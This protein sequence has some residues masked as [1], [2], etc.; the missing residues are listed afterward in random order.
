SDP[1]PE[2][3]QRMTVRHAVGEASLSG[4]DGT[5]IGAGGNDEVFALGEVGSAWFGMATDPFWA[6][7]AALAVFIDSRSRGEDAPGVFGPTPNNVFTD[8]NVVAIALQLPNAV[9]GGDEVALWA[10]ITL[11]GHAGTTRVSRTGNPMVR[12]L[13]FPDR[14][15]QAEDLNAGA[16]SD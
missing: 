4:T 13:F 1:D 2:G 14:D 6:D 10:R 15:Q 11:Y 8:R 5:V 9:F 7:G 16:P 12:P 3:H